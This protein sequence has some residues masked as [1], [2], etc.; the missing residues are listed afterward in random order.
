MAFRS[1]NTN[2]FMVAI[3]VPVW[4][5][6]ES[7]VIGVL[8]RT[9]HLGDL[10]KRWEQRI[11]DQSD[12]D[13]DNESR[14]LTLVDMR[15]KPAIVLDHHWMSSDENLRAIADEVRVKEYLELRPDEEAALRTAVRGG[16]GISDY[17]DPLAN[18]VPAYADTWLAA[19]AP[20][21]TIDWMAIVQERRTEAVQPMSDLYGTFWQYGVII[22]LAYC[23]I[24][25]VQWRILK[26]IVAF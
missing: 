9:L 15:T 23:V 7:E 21:N 16:A 25:F 14:F 24:F 13:V 8:A 18:S 6:D 17:Q 12:E 26:R 11:Y 4:N 19:V 2:Q 20:V 10:L 1:T 22:T 3:A 5:R